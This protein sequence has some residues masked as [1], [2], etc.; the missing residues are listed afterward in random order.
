MWDYVKKEIQKEIEEK[1]AR[2][3]LIP[4]VQQALNELGSINVVC[5]SGDTATQ[6]PHIIY[7]GV[8]KV[9]YVVAGSGAIRSVTRE[10]YNTKRYDTAVFESIYTV[11]IEALEGIIEVSRR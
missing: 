11:P 10:A 8:L 6:K 1:E 9:Y 3:T 2:N 4:K 7:K 5:S